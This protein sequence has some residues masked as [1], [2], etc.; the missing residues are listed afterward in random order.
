[1]RLGR[2]SALGLLIPDLRNPFYTSFAHLLEIEAEK[3]GY[4]LVLESWRMNLSREKHCLINITERQVDG[5]ATFLSD[6][7]THRPFLEEQSAKRRAFVAL[8]I[9]G[10]K[11]LPVDCVLTDFSVGLR[12]P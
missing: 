1:M 9:T 8:S 10:G 6:N 7:E 12:E 11:A 4:D 3:A 5:A 2:F